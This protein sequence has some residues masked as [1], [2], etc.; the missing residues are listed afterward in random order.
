MGHFSVS[1]IISTREY[2]QVEVSVMNWNLHMVMIWNTGECF[3]IFHSSSSLSLFCLPLCKVDII[4][5]PRKKVYKN[6]NRLFR[7]NKYLQWTNLTKISSY[8]R[9]NY[10][11]IR[12]IARSTRISNWE[13]GIILFY[14][15]YWQGNIWSITTW[16]RDTCL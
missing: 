12:W 16:L 10:W 11:C 4:S 13:I 3:T 8:F 15:W 2:A 5:S 7:I 1:F 14:L 9:F 6:K